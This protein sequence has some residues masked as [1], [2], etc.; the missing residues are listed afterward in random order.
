MAP[1]K[2][3]PSLEIIDFI[4]GW[5]TCELTPYQDVAG[6]WTCGWGHL[7]DADEPREKWTQERAD[8]QFEFDLALRAADPVRKHVKVG[9][10]QC[11]FDALV[12]FTFNVG[13]ARLRD[14]TLLVYLNRGHFALASAEFPKWR[15]A[16]GRV[17][18]GLVKR[19][20]AER[21][22]FGADYMG[23]P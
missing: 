23:R 3:V 8:T 10:A 22:I 13:A 14:S 2:R 17:V 9:L 4:K 1:V 12:S 16:G 19:R 6:Y 11:Q 7:L 20:A 15:M 18:N 5:E 21:A